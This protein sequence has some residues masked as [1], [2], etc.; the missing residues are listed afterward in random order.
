MSVGHRGER[1][2]YLTEYWHLYHCKFNKETF[3]IQCKF[4]ALHNNHCCNS[5]PAQSRLLFTLLVCLIESLS[6]DELPNVEQGLY[7]MAPITKSSLGLKNMKYQLSCLGKIVLI[8]CDFNWKRAIQREIHLE[9]LGGK[10]WL[11]LFSGLFSGC[12]LLIRQSVNLT[13]KNESWRFSFSQAPLSRFWR[14]K[15]SQEPNHFVF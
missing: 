14:V 8:T 2:V 7:W 15:C 3:I 11:R 5:T 10:A 12:S 9:I 6:R 1:R 13:V 4:T